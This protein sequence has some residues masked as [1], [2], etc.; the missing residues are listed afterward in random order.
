MLSRFLFGCSTLPRT[1]LTGQ[2]SFR[3]GSI[4]H[5]RH[6][7]YVHKVELARYI[8]CHGKKDVFRTLFLLPW[9]TERAQ[10]L[11]TLLLVFTFYAV[12]SSKAKILLLYVI[13][14]NPDCFKLLTASC[15]V[16]NKFRDNLSILFLVKNIFI[17][18]Q[19]MLLIAS[20]I[21]SFSLADYSEASPMCYW[22]CTFATT[23]SVC[24]NK[25]H[26]P[27]VHS[28]LLETLWKIRSCFSF[29]DLCPIP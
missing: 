22:H 28:T 12:M 14:L 8:V 7:C 10:R 5:R 24:F 9:S 29:Q 27:S 20:R 1:P 18:L 21:H 2:Y 26:R 19:I 23:I 11:R 25:A 17:D 3:E 16:F 4:Y 13:W 6:R 15:M